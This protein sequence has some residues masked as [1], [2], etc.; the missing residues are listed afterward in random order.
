M[1]HQEAVPPSARHLGQRFWPGTME[2]Q[3]PGEDGLHLP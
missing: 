1:R 2:T 3:L